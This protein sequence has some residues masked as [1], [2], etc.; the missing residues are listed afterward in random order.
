MKYNFVKVFRTIGVLQNK[1]VEIKNIDKY[2]E[3]LKHNSEFYKKIKE[4]APA[5]SNQGFNLEE[6]LKEKTFDEVLAHII[7]AYNKISLPQF[8]EEELE[9]MENGYNAVGEEVKKQF[10]TFEVFKKAI[11]EDEQKSYEN[12][13]KILNELISQLQD[14]KPLSDSLNRELLEKDARKKQLLVEGEEMYASLP[15]NCSLDLVRKGLETKDDFPIIDENSILTSFNPS[16]KDSINLDDL[17]MVH[18]TSYFPENGVIKSS[19]DA[20]GSKRNTVH[21]S[22]NGRVG[23]HAYG[24][25]DGIPMVILDPLKEHI[26]QVACLY[27]ADTFTYGSMK[28]SEQATILIDVNMFDEIYQNNKDYIDNNRDK[29]ILFSGDSLKVVKRLL[30]IMGYVPEDIGMWNWVNNHDADLLD[31][32]IKNNYPYKL[33]TSH[34]HTPYNDV[35]K[36]EFRGDVLNSFGIVDDGNDI[37]VGLDVLYALRQRGG[38]KHMPIEEFIKRVGVFVMD[39]EIHLLGIKDYVALMQ[40]EKVSPFQVQKVGLLL[41]KYE[42]MLQKGILIDNEESHSKTA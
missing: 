26:D 19:R 14:V 34:N 16:F 7:D 30:G 5:F 33:S 11:L 24:N 13:K 1:K 31:N 23:S 38:N 28:L 29:I 8:S 2:V 39:D 3:Q 17:I 10:P 4:L 36:D 22:L 41:Q 12:R 42:L 40:A 32:F 15:K 21:T 27:A 6:L 37:V 18:A 20:I 9:E 35:E 25:W